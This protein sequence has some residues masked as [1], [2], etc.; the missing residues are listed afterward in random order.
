MQTVILTRS[1]G[2]C[3]IFEKIKETYI[4]I[5]MNLVSRFRKEIKMRVNLNIVFSAL[6]HFILHKKVAS[7]YLQVIITSFQIYA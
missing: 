5:V 1:H 2:N 6:C 3:S 4:S 7:I